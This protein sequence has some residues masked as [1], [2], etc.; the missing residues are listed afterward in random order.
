MIWSMRSESLINVVNRQQAKRAERLD[1][2][3][4][5]LDR[6]FPH[7]LTQTECHRRTGET[8]VIRVCMQN[9]ETPSFPR[10]RESQL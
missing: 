7:V 4:T 8:Y 6:D 3:G 1:P 2:K 5:W 9:V 10:H